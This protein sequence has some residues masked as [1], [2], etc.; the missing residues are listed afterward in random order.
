MNGSQFFSTM[1]V[2]YKLH[3]GGTSFLSNDS[4]DPLSSGCECEGYI[5]PRKVHTGMFTI[6][7]PFI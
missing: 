4:W 7:F 5:P 3:G 6:E 2:F 1:V